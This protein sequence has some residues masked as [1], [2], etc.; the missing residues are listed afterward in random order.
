[1]AE[2]ALLT[3]S[4]KK[5]YRDVMWETFMNINAIGKTWDKQQF[6]EEDK[7]CSRISRYGSDNR[8]RFEE[9]LYKCN[10]HRKTCSDFQSFQEHEMRKSGEKPHQYEQYGEANSDLTEQTLPWEKTFL[11]GLDS[12][13]L[14]ECGTHSSASHLLFLRHHQQETVTV[15]DVAVKFTMAEWALLNPSQKKLYRA[16]MWETLRNIYAVGRTWDQQQTGE[17]DKNCSRNLRYNAHNYLRFEE[18]LYECNEYGKSCSDFQSFEEHEMRTVK[19]PCL[20]GQGVKAT[21]DLSEQTHHGQKT[22]L[23][24]KSMKVPTTLHDVQMH[25]R[26]QRLRSPYAYKYFENSFISSYFIQNFERR[27]AEENQRVNTKCVKT[28]ALSNSFPKHNKIH[29]GD[30]LYVYKHYRKAFPC[31]SSFHKHRISHM[32]EKTYVSKQCRKAF[33]RNSICQNHERAHTGEKPYACQTCG[34]IFS[35]VTGCTMHDRTHTGEKPYICKQCGKAFSQNGTLLVHKRIHSGEKPYVCKQCGKAF[36]QKSHL[37]VHERIHTGEK[38]YVCKQCGKAFSQNGTLL[39][40]E[41]SHTGEKSHVCKQCGKEFS[42]NGHLV[43][44]ERIHTGEKP[45]ACKQCEK[46][47]SIKGNLVVHER[48]HTGEKPYA[49]VQCGK[50]FSIN[51]NLLKHERIHTGEKPYVCKQCGKEFIQNCHLIVH[52]RSHTGEKPYVCKQ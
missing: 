39:V 5:L 16:V 19:K 45:Y 27:H 30:I 3:P 4:Q 33:K 17:E 20:Y 47:F 13:S 41:R 12:D 24:K 44:H 21:C 32:E 43:V 7:N 26:K 36:R 11:G 46:A 51:G 52:E 38:P 35:T 1:M 15:E 25:K 50:A 10:E 31:K 2:W 29:T 23:G 28:L 18:K 37:V 34:K 6:G 49:C 22:L 14:Q 9:K 48:I 40:H 8:L 42:R